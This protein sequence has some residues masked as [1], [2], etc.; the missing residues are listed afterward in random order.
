[1]YLEDLDELELE[2]CAGQEIWIGFHSSTCP[3]P[4]KLTPFVE[5]DFFP[6]YCFG[7]FVKDQDTRCLSLLCGL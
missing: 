6:Q 5:D 1:M 2:F 3:V 7:F 4:I